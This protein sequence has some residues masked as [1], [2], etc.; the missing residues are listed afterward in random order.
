MG[1]DSIGEFEHLILLAILR[2]RDEA[3]GTTIF[4]ELGQHTDRP[5]LRPAVYNALRRLEAK[6][7]LRSEIGE[8]TSER[9]GRAKRYV[10]LTAAGVASLQDS[11]RTLMSLWDGVAGA[12]D[13]IG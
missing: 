7:L 3:Y 2:L 11:R 10:R 13:D 5:I 6:G 8:P 4:D 12:L 1:R 9:G